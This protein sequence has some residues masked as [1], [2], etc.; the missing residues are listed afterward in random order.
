MSPETYRAH[1]NLSRHEK[2]SDF[3]T[4]RLN[5]LPQNATYFTV[6]DLLSNP[7]TV[8]QLPAFDLSN[9]SRDA[10]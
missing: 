5:I 3:W 9:G 7:D 10:E 1:D 6:V 2:Y 8:S 4:I